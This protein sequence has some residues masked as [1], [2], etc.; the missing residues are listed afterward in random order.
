M[1]RVV[2]LAMVVGMSGSIQAAEGVPAQNVLADMGLAGMTIMTDAEASAIRGS[3]FKPTDLNGFAD[4]QQS[5]NEFHEHVADFRERVAAFQ[6]RIE[7][8]IHKGKD[9][10]KKSKEN[11]HKN[12]KKFHRGT[13]KFRHKNQPKMG[14]GGMKHFKHGHGGKLRV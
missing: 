7:R 9:G 1:R 13:K 8:H 12:M 4:Y 14:H 2:A 5:I 3:G 11:F 6:G 10:L